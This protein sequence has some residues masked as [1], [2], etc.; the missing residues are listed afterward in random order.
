[1]EY[2]PN[3]ILIT[4]G[5]GFIGSNFINYF[6]EKHPDK[7][8][9]NLD[10]LDYCANKN[11]VIN[12]TNYKLVIGDINNTELVNYILEENNIDTVIHFAAQ[13]HVD[14][15]FGNSINF[16]TDN[17]KGTH[18]L[19]ECCRVYNKIKRFIHISTDEV[20]GQVSLNHPGCLENTFEL[21]PTNPYAAT[22]LGAEY[23]VKSY[24][25]SF[26]L[27]IIITRGNNVFGPRQHFE[28][29]IPRF[30]KLLNENNL[31]TIHGQGAARRN[32][33]H[34]NDVVTAIETILYKGTI[35]EIYNIGSHNEY[36][37]MDIATKLINI[38]K[39][40]DAINSWIKYVDDR[41]FNDFRYAINC[42]KLKNL[43]W[44]ET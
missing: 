36:S 12:K 21:D 32:F 19:L 40:N 28:K 24:Y 1:M 22:K 11:N 23:L 33:I 34:V 27:P 13:T 14:N 9:I 39:P 35:N 38:L 20:Y 17:I 6:H 29:L 3:N 7:Q 43:G 16:S 44:K 5:A 2:Q 8:I 4:G 18:T 41:Y 30:I 37:V 42:D 26:K 31:C 15:S 25:H 10:R